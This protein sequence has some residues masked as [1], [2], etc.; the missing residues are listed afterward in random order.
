M[1]TRSRCPLSRTTEY[2]HPPQGGGI[3]VSVRASF[4]APA[5][6][7]A[8]Y[9][10][11]TVVG[12]LRRG[13]SQAGGKAPTLPRPSAIRTRDTACHSSPS[14]AGTHST[15]FGGLM[16]SLDLTKAVGSRAAAVR[17]FTLSEPPERGERWRQ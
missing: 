9:V 6:R 10:G 14:I 11:R 13:V 5:R 15:S 4:D 2:T 8:L 3:R 1:P 12:D 17:T 16:L 7:E